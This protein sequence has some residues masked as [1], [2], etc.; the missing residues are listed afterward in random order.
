MTNVKRSWPA[1]GAPLKLKTKIHEHYMKSLQEL[2]KVLGLSQ[3]YSEL[4]K[5]R[6][7]CLFNEAGIRSQ[8]PF[9][10]PRMILLLKF[11]ELVN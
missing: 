2:A 5:F 9:S 6:K 1:T 8:E 4:K 10:A 3:G 7:S 11:K